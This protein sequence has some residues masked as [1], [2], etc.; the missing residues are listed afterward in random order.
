MFPFNH[1]R[2]R[3]HRAAAIG[4]LFALT[5]LA[6]AQN[7]PKTIPAEEFRNAIERLTI[8]VGFSG[9]SE[10]TKEKISKL[11][12][13]PEFLKMVREEY[14]ELKSRIDRGSATLKDIPNTPT[15]RK[16]ID[17]FKGIAPLTSPGSKPP[18]PKKVLD[19][20]KNSQ[21]PPTNIAEREPSK[22]PP[23][24]PPLDPQPGLGPHSVPTQAYLNQKR[25]Q[26]RVAQT[27]SKLWERNFGPLENNPGL[28]RAI[29]DLVDAGEDIKG[30]D[31]NNFW[32]FLEQSA[33]DKNGVEDFLKDLNGITSNQPGSAWKW[34]KFDLPSMGK[35][36][37]GNWDGE[38]ETSPSQG[39]ATPPPSST[40]GSFG[41]IGGDSWLPLIL[42]LALAIG[43][44]FL[45]RFGKRSSTEQ[46]VLE[47][48]RHLGP[49]PV[50]PRSLASREDVVK[51]L[52]YLALLRNGESA[53]SWNHIKL[54]F[55]L[56]SRSAEPIAR[57]YAQSRYAPGSEPLTAEELAEARRL[58]CRL[59]G[60]AAV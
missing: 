33:G 24:I 17:K 34:P 40:S 19:S 1:T 52:E 22:S 26:E 2:Q 43:G 51:A 4:L 16:A 38:K 30:N 45:W 39:T 44:L 27:L 57:L 31:G 6:Y 49:W 13:N 32:Q 18:A 20:T 50:N 47:V 3:A 35:W 12:R 15:L 7:P 8:E 59:A 36:E 10:E 37:W 9:Y 25:R 56:E 48:Q 11:L 23:P 53:R 14:P 58:V 46:S 55:E 21:P 5:G 29:K 41:A 54:A 42:L 28:R 60:V